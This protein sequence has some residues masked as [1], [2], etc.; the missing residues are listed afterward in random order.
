[1]RDAK[2]SRDEGALPELSFRSR[3]LLTMVAGCWGQVSEILGVESYFIL[4]E[5]GIGVQPKCNLRFYAG[6]GHAL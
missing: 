1:M 2:G 6:W 4:L 5:E 3:Q